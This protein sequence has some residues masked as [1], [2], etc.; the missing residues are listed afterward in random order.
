MAHPKERFVS[1]YD[2]S[3][4]AYAHAVRTSSYRLPAAVYPYWKYWA[5]GRSLRVLDVGCGWG[6]NP[7]HVAGGGSSA[8]AWM[9]SSERGQLAEEDAWDQ[10][11]VRLSVRTPHS[12]VG[13][14]RAKRALAWGEHVGLYDQTLSVDLAEE[15]PGDVG[16]VDFVLATGSLGYMGPSVVSRLLSSTGS[17]PW[18]FTLLAWEDLD[19]WAAAFAQHGRKLEETACVAQRHPL[20]EGERAHMEVS[21][22]SDGRS[23]AR[24]GELVLD[25]GFLPAYVLRVPA[26]DNS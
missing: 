4:Q 17:A 25:A 15:S 21:L 14:D 6:L 24:S 9:T 19:S 2:E 3:P 20:T 12:W 13:L 1:D 23:L 5:A 10:D 11:R 8:L 7:L 22:R 26:G 16:P 18:L